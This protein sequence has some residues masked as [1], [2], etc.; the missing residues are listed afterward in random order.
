MLA[1][2]GDKAQC[3][4][5]EEDAEA[6]ALVTAE[7]PAIDRQRLFAPHFKMPRTQQREAND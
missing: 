3:Q 6:P 2:K 4:L 5:A 7:A 1:R